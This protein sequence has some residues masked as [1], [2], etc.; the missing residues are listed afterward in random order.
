MSLVRRIVNRAPWSPA[1]ERRATSSRLGLL[2]G[3]SGAKMGTLRCYRWVALGVVAAG[4]ATIFLCKIPDAKAYAVSC[5]DEYVAGTITQTGGPGPNCDG[6]TTWYVPVARNCT[7]DSGQSCTI[8]RTE[9]WTESY[10]QDEGPPKDPP[11]I[12]QDATCI[13]LGG[14]WQQNLSTS[15]GC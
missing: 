14:Q 11:P 15:D 12:D 8:T 2:A 4:V 6:T 1:H 13:S 10:Y 5:G 3:T 9:V 7:N